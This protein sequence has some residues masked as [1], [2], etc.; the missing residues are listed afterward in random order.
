MQGRHGEEAFDGTLLPF[1]QGLMELHH[2][3]EEGGLGEG[4]C[5][6]GVHRVG[7]AL[8]REHLGDEQV[9][10]VGLEAIAVLERAGH[11]VGEG[12]PGLGVAAGTV[13]DL[14]IGVIHHLLEDDVD[15]RVRRSCPRQ[16][17]SARSS[18]QRAQR[19][20]VSTLTRSRVRV[21]VQC[22]A[23]CTGPLALAPGR[24]SAVSSSAVREDGRLELALLLGVVFSIN[25]AINTPSSS[26][27]ASTRARLSALILPS[28]HS[29]SKRALSVSSSS[30][31]ECPLTV[32]MTRPRPPSSPPAPPSA[33]AP[34]AR[35]SAGPSSPPCA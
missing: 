29:A 27:N 4:L 16:S 8:E 26:S 10:D 17:V 22:S 6:E 19:S 18:P 33:R 20:T 7:D 32:A 31:S 2:V 15:E 3:V 9:H 28:A 24:A 11:R 12:R 13:L 25:T 35:R 21:L 1:G 34:A 5:D 30:V 14:C 23:L